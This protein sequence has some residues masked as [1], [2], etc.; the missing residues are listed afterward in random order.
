VY[1]E[2]ARAL[3]GARSASYFG[4]D[5]RARELVLRA[6]T[7]L[8]A[9]PE[10]PTRFPAGRGLAGTAVTTGRPT[11]CRDATRDPRFHRPPG[12]PPDTA[13]VLSLPLQEA[14]GVRGVVNLTWTD[15]RE[16]P[17][18]AHLEHLEQAGADLLR[19]L[20]PGS[21]V[22]PPGKF[23]AP[24][25]TLQRHGLPAPDQV[26]G[27]RLTH[28]FRP[29]HEV[30]GDLLGAWTSEA[31]LTTLC[32][33]DASGHDAGSAMLATM[34]R[35]VLARGAREDRPL[36]A[37]A[38]ELDEVISTDAPVGWFVT[39]FLIRLLPAEDR[40]EFLGSGHPP[41]LLQ[42][43]HQPHVLT[44]DS[45]AAGAG[46]RGPIPAAGGAPWPRGATLLLYTD[47]LE[48][49][50]GGLRARAAL[51]ERLAAVRHGPIEA[52]RSTLVEDHDRTWDVHAD[53]VAALA[54][55]RS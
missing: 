46:M 45:Q 44:L 38:R 32:V 13:S 43:P 14:D 5:E 24:A 53:D 34:A 26:P 21:D 41:A 23:M 15:P 52:L 37:L 30:G 18:R 40:L 51:S 47:G 22:L 36:E 33:A 6:A 20:D 11:F 3:S 9:P 42:L 55:R 35:A 48:E 19:R 31:G 12:P 29:L 39:H 54:L 17:P 7:F 1:L 8:D 10:D 2:Y 27:H 50:Y 25:R 4:W 16:R 49:L 28:L